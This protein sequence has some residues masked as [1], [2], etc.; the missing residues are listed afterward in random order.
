MFT[1]RL[2]TR[3]GLNPERDGGQCEDRG[4]TTEAIYSSS[5]QDYD[6]GDRRHIRRG[7][8][9]SLMTSSACRDR[10]FSHVTVKTMEGW[11]FLFIIKIGVKIS[12]F[13]TFMSLCC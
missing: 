11:I 8:R 7:Q 12:P 2:D 9:E 10:I 1:A 6:S 4:H 5:D 3:Q 13:F